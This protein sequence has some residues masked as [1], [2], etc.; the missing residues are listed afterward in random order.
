VEREV[1]LA[2]ADL[3]SSALAEM[4]EGRRVEALTAS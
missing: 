2:D 4:L 3:V 1:L